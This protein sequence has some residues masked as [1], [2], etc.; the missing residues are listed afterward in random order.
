MVTMHEAILTLF[1]T[2]KPL[3]DFILVS[4]DNGI[5]ITKWNPALGTQPTAEQL[6]AVTQEQVDAAKSAKFKVL[7]K[8]YHEGVQAEN[9][10]LRATVALVVDELNILREWLSDFKTEVAA[11]TNLANLQTRIASLP[12]MQDRTYQQAKTA[13]KTLID[14][15]L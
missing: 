3:Q 12:N 11:A 8:A 13:I 15:G 1:P 9:V 6:A 14:N 10:A 4:S 5:E 7:T 2:A